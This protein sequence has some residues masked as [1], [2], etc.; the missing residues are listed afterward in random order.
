MCVQTIKYDEHGEPDRVKSRIVALG[1]HED[2][3]WRN[4]SDRYALVIGQPNHQTLTSIAVEKGQ[5]QKQG[6]CK[7]AFLHLWLPASK[8]TICQPPPGCPFSRPDDYWL[9]Q[10]TIYGLR[11]SPHHWF[12]YITD[13]LK[14]LGLQPIANDPWCIY[15][16][17][18]VTGEPPI[19]IGVY[20]DDFTYFSCSDVTKRNLRTGYLLK[21]K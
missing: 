1:N 9:L 7:N 12:K 13:V 8:I 19:Y 5:K 2:N 4:S 21:L 16:G 6:D 14:R 3:I 17:I 10:K 11:Q 20:V 15:T 18:L